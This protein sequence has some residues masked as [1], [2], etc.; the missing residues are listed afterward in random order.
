MIRQ[1][2]YE[3]VS[4]QEWHEVLRQVFSIVNSDGTLLSADKVMSYLVEKAD[5]LFEAKI[6]YSDKDW[7]TTY[8]ENNQTIMNYA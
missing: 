7:L 3:M 2:P 1:F 6:V 5:E 8:R 4:K